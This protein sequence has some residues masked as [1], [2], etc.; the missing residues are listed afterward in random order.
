VEINRTLVFHP[1][2]EILPPKQWPPWP[3]QD[4]A[5]HRERIRSEVIPLGVKL[6]VAILSIDS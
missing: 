5:D 4:V 1:F 6:K 2:M 3:V